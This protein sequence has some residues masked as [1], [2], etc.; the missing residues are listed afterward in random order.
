MSQP[1]T[2][3]GGEPQIRVGRPEDRRG[4]LDQEGEELLTLSQVCQRHGSLSPWRIGEGMD[5]V[6]HGAVSKY[7]S[8]S[9]APM[10]GKHGHVPMP[11]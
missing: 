5:G 7:G 1:T 8:R 4:M 9:A 11:T 2:E 6:N 3:G 10:A